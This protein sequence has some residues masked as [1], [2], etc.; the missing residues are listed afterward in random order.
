MKQFLFL[1][2]KDWNKGGWF[3]WADFRL[4]GGNSYVSYRVG[5]FIF[6][7]K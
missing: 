6:R 7:R 1:G 2:W 3:H 4:N 5:P